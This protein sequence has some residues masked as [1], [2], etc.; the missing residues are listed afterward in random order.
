MNNSW[1]ASIRNDKKLTHEAVAG[2]A[3]IE[4]SYYTKIENGL[5]PSV[6]VAKRIARVLGFDWTNFFNQDCDVKSQKV[7]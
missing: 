2:L 6:K 3:R 5:I 1:L 7:M 4:R